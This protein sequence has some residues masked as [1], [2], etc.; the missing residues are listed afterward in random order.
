[1]ENLNSLPLVTII[2]PVYNASKYLKRCLE[3]VLNQSYKTLEIILIDDGSNDGSLGIM[4]SYS[5]VDKRIKLYHKKNSGPSDTRN[6]GLQQAN[7]DYICFIDADD[8]VE[9]NYIQVFIDVLFNNQRPDLLITDY[10]EYSKHHP[11]GILQKQLEKSG[12][13]EIEV[14]MPNLFYGVM[15]VLWGKMFKNSIIKENQ[16]FFE[17]KIRYQ[18]D[19]LFIFFYLNNCKSVYYSSIPTYHYNR[20]NEYSITSIIKPSYVAEFEKIQTLLLANIKNDSIYSIVL[21]RS[22]IFY[23]NYILS[24]AI[25]NKY[26]SFLSYLKDVDYSKYVKDYKGNLIYNLF[27]LLI[28][29]KLPLLA[30]HYLSF[31][32]LLKKIKN[33]LNFK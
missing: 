9:I 20:L 29:L 7:G 30:Y 2:I 21:D 25:H 22:S 10:I 5:A 14:F 32:T 27:F 16:L 33:R 18:E 24:L 11:R 8:Y 23:C 28:F 13:Y 31:I 19:L 6:K 12:C 17:S 15:G 1:M 26:N 4:Q 3:S